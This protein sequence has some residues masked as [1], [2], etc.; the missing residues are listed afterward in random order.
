MKRKFLLFTT[1]VILGVSVAAL[2]QTVLDPLP[3]ALVCAYN[4]SPP[5]AT[6]GTF[7]LVQCNSSG[8]LVLH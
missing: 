4:T 5:V 2:A 3:G 7:I 6:S 8:Q 1:F